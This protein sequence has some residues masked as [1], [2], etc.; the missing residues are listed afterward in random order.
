MYKKIFLIAVLWITFSKAIG[1]PYNKSYNYLEDPFISKAAKDYFSGKFKAR[2]DDKTLSIIDSIRTKNTVARP[3][4]LFLVSK[5]AIRS[6]ASLS[7][8]IGV[9]LKWFVEQK[10]DQF[11]EFLTSMP[12]DKASFIDAWAKLT[13]GEILIS[14]ENK[15][16]LCIDKSRL[17]ANSKTKSNNRVMLQDFY[18]LVTK[19]CH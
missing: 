9:H 3:F 13:A 4:Y 15:V 11:I 2:D 19:Y 16:K 6:D 1:Q 10:P 12:D 17:L 7:E 5:M 14:C 18:V 8:E